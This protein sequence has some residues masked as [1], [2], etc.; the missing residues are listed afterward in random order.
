MRRRARPSLRPSRDIPGGSQSLGLAAHTRLTADRA[1]AP[2]GTRKAKAD[3]TREQRHT[4]SET[5][6]R[7]LELVPNRDM[8][9]SA[10][11]YDEMAEDGI[12]ASETCR[13]SGRRWWSR[14]I[15][16]TRKGRASLSGSSIGAAAR[17]TSCGAFRR[18][19][20]HPQCSSPPTGLI[21]LDGQTISFGGS[22][23]QE[24]SY[25][26]GP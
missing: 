19:R 24:A 2:Q 5:L 9:I 20:H 10:H 6:R 11:G 1:G 17:F 8:R 22:R 25:Q 13:V 23:E 4:M 18:A 21:Q 16:S 3:E 12:L 14:I 7:V 26:A 15:P